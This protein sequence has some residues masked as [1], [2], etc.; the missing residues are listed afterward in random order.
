MPDRGKP[1]W[2]RV[3]IGWIG[4]LWSP[5]ANRRRVRRNDGGTRLGV[6]GAQPAGEVRH[7]FIRPHPGRPPV[8][9]RQ[10][11]PGA[12]ILLRLALHP[13]IH[14]EAVGSV[15]FHPDEGEVVLGNQSPCERSSPAVILGRAMRRLAQKNESGITDRCQ[16]RIQARVVG[17]RR[18]KVANLRGRYGQRQWASCGFSCSA[19]LPEFAPPSGS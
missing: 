14:S 11:V 6:V 3:S 4:L 12:P 19:P 1:V 10:H 16:K 17:E 15:T 8:E 5:T 18:G 9:L 7:L 2:T 13:T